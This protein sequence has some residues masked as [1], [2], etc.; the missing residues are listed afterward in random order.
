[1]EITRNNYEIFIIDYFDGKLDAAEVTALKLF[2]G[3]NP[4]LQEEFESLETIRIDDSE[5]LAFEEKKKLKRYIISSGD[6][7]SEENYLKYSVEDMDGRLDES[8]KAELHEFLEKNPSLKRDYKLLQLTR[9]V[10]E[11]IVYPAKDSLKKIPVIPVY[12][13]RA[14]ISSI[15]AAIALLII[16][17]SIYLTVSNN[18]PS[19]AI[20]FKESFD[21]QNINRDVVPEKPV[22]IPE[23]KNNSDVNFAQ[24]EQPRQN[25]NQDN[26]LPQNRIV[27]HY[28]LDQ[29]VSNPQLAS[30]PVSVFQPVIFVTGYQTTY[31]DIMA[32]IE[33]KQEIKNTSNSGE[34]KSLGEYGMDMVNKANGNETEKKETSRFT[35]WDLAEIGV[36]GYNALSA[37]DVSVNHETDAEGKTVAFAIGNVGYSR[38]K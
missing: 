16:A 29:M 35:I 12:R 8:L 25:K 38:K 22:V 30:L 3:Q 7:I 36:A 26:N 6:E 21:K 34:K 4:D 24:N 5:P 11:T 14:F 18:K 31:T 20:A 37:K 13:R 28:Q 17:A 27:E 33:A 1:M 15:A 9:L 19:K 23:N 32:Y 2:L 10:P